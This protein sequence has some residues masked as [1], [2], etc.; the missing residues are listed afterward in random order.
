MSNATS[1][2][3]RVL[4][5]FFVVALGVVTLAGLTACG[6][7]G[8]DDGTSGDTA[9]AA[10]QDMPAAGSGGQGAM[11]ELQRVRK[12]LSAISEEAMQDSALQRQLEELR[13]LIDETMREMSPRAGKQMDRMDTLRGQVQTAQS[14]GDTARL[15]ELMT[16]AQGLQRSLQKIRNKAMR[17]EEVAA[18][19]KDFRAALQEKMREID[20]AAD[21]LMDRADSLQQEM[22]SQAQGMMGGGAG[23][24]TS[25]G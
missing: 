23:S 10:M 6:G 11:M 3:S 7:D 13:A 9:S 17:Q 12:E 8:Q 2:T 15:R 18:T 14:Q 20:P 24:D 4:R 5:S 19:L 1:P 22:Q 25:G 16:E 21:S